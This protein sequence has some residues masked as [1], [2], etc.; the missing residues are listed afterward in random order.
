MSLNLSIVGDLQEKVFGVGRIE[1][2]NSCFIPPGKEKEI[3]GLGKGEDCC[4]FLT[5]SP[6]GFQCEKFNSYLAMQLL[7]RLDK[8][9][10]NAKRIGNCKLIPK[11]VRIPS[12]RVRR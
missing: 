7:Y 2:S 6:E 1:D 10:I 9:E 8:G 11:T 5:L 4:I 3:C 12:P